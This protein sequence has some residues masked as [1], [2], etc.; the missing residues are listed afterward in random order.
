MS[1]KIMLEG[2]LPA[3]ISMLVTA[4]HTL[5]VGNKMLHGCGGSTG[6][7]F[8]SGLRVVLDY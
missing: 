8:L 5:D 7:T 4:H 1:L 3:T 6:S 2:L